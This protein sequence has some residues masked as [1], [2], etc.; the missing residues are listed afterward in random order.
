MP[1]SNTQTPANRQTRIPPLC[2]EALIALFL[3]LAGLCPPAQAARHPASRGGV[4]VQRDMQT[5][6]AK[7]PFLRFTL[8]IVKGTWDVR[9]PGGSALNGVFCGAKL[10]DGTDLSSP[11]DTEHR[12]GAGDVKRISDHLGKG[13]EITV[14]HRSAGRP[15]LREEF[16]IYAHVPYLITRVE[17][18][19][20]NVMSTNDITPLQMDGAKQ[21]GSEL[22]IDAGTK[23]Q[24]LRVPFDN[25]N[26]VRYNSRKPAAGPDSW[27]VTAVYDNASRH[28]MVIG[29]LDYD[30]WKAGVDLGP[31]TGRSLESLR[32][33][34]GATGTLS[35][36]TQPHGSVSGTT[37]TSP[38]V[39]VGAFTDWRDGLETFGKAAARLH[40]P[41]RWDGGVPFGWNSWGAFATKIHYDNYVAVADFFKH[42]LQ[43]RG[44]HHHGTVYINMD[45]FWDNLSD[46][47][48]LQAVRHIHAQ[49]Q[50]AGIY[51]TPF[52]L[53][54]DDFKRT[55]PG[56][57]GRYTFGDILLK[58]AAGHP[59]PKLD[60]GH[61]IDPSHPGELLR[62]DAQ[63]KKF[64]SQGFDYVKLD[65]I[66][67]GALEG[68]HFDPKV[69]TGMEAYSEGMKRIAA[70]L[71][72]RK[73][74]RPFFIS[75]S[76]APV[77]SDGFA[78]S[79]RISCDVFGAL[80]NVEY[81]LN[82][83]TYGWWLN[84]TAYRY[85]DPDIAILYRSGKGKIIP[86]NVARSRVNSC[87]I[88]GTV[89][90]D[91]DDLTDPG[92]QNRVVSLLTNPAILN[93]ARAGRTFRPVEGDTGD[94]AADVF[95]RRDPDGRFYVAVFN[96]DGQK[97]QTISLDLARLGL[98]ANRTYRALDLWT[99]K[100]VEARG[101]LSI[102]LAPGDSTILR[103]TR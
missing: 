76:I 82:S 77:F 37:I 52:T 48:I 5:V 8:S 45:S 35:R 89:L 61:P 41:L 49:G 88:A 53:W 28:G 11:D 93:V 91:S 39:F 17:I 100:S 26:F 20:P 43:P 23:L 33:Y 80:S 71:D 86:L 101:Q 15:E 74:G 81:M 9:W 16:W 25:D 73:I 99:G 68:A 22:L 38:R 64:V 29:A 62:I 90:L 40:P 34:G 59:L 1:L 46:A 24:L 57:G 4:M 66:N 31:I 47:Q 14:H 96:F 63:L 27:G 3:I 55:V 87:V 2:S 75:L 79:R 54:G 67:A 42:Q 83:L 102:D 84:G 65:F 21:S 44:F 50:K 98:S 12:C 7:S 30:V 56:T 6:Q 18:V 19:S 103:I 94:R 70:D 13:V 78:H 85:N 95:T 60:G 36:D 51:W 69:T 32:V 58:D 97:A 10:A 72:P 92:A